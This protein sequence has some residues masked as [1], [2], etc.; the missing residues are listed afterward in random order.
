VFADVV[1]V[2]ELLAS[3][4]FALT[5]L[6]APLATVTSASFIYPAVVAGATPEPGVP[7]T[8]DKE[9]VISYS[10]YIKELDNP[11][12]DVLRYLYS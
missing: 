2:D 3:F 6:D 12:D 11:V 1:Q 5:I 7:W 4:I 10:V 8:T 9:T